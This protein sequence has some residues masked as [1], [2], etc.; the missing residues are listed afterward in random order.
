MHS[1]AVEVNGELVP[2]D[3]FLGDAVNMNQSRIQFFLD[4]KRKYYWQFELSL[5]PDRPRWALE[6]GKAFHEAMAVL[7]GKD[8]LELAVKTAKQTLQDSMPKQKLV[9]DANELRD[10]VELVERMVRGYHKEY[11]GKNTYVPLGIE[12]EGRVEIGEGTGVFL[13]F[14]TDR[15]CNWMGRL[16]ILDHK[17][18][19]KLDMRDV[20]KY[21]MDLQFTAYVYGASKIL[22]QRVAGVIVDVVTKAQNMKF[23]QEPYVRSDNDLLEFEAEFVEMAREIAWR[24]ARVKAGEDPKTVWYKNTKECFR[25][26]TCSYRDLCLEDTPTKRALFMR[27]DPDY[28]DDANRAGRDTIDPEAVNAAHQS[29]LEA[30]RDARGA[31]QQGAEHPDDENADHAPGGRGADSGTGP[32]GG[33]GGEA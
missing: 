24:R 26:G 1:F 21:E 9:Y 12:C 8:D 7:A 13:V 3:E 17:T 15:L 6:V 30:A 4:C 28:V 29:H 2:F 22:G 11:E 16:W 23:H 32:D 14:R 20:M 5:V 31:D 18:A 10:N 33:P 25:Y 19:A 27:R